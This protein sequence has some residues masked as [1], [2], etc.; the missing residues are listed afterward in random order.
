LRD[1]HDRR[2]RDRRHAERQ[3][4]KRR[5]QPACS[6]VAVTQRN[7][8]QPAVLEQRDATRVAHFLGE[9][10]RHAVEHDAL[11]ACGL[12]IQL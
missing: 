3:A 10:V 12:C 6:L 2:R 1:H 11:L 4:H 5:E 9:R 8:V 7:R